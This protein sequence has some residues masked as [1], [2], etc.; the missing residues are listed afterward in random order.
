VW[1]EVIIFDI[2]TGREKLLV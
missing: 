2:R 1:D